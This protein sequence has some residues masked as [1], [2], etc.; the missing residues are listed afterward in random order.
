MNGCRVT[1]PLPARR[2]NGQSIVLVVL[3]MVALL[4]M[5][6]VAI[7]VGY[8]LL[9]KRR[10]QSAVD[11][12]LL[13]GARDLPNATKAKNR[14]VEFVG[15]NFHRVTDQAI[16]TNA[17]TGCMNAGCG[18]HDKISLSA[19][20][21]TPTFF[22]KL[23]G[24]DD[25]TV[26]AR[27]AACGPC[28]SSPFAYDVVVVLDRSYS[29]CLNAWGGS[30]GCSDLA[31][32]KAGVRELLQFFDPDT[33]RVSLA[34]LSSAD[35]NSCTG[36]PSCPSSTTYGR[37]YSHTGA[38]SSYS[39][40]TGSAAG[41]PYCNDSASPSHA[42]SG[43]NGKFY[44]SAGDFMDGNAANHDRW[45]LVS[46]A[47]G[48]NFK[49]ANGT[50]N[51]NSAFLNTLDCIQHK[52]WT[53]IAPAIYEATEELRLNGRTVDDND[54]PVTKVIVFLGDG[55]G[56]AQPM[57]R[58]ND[59]TPT[60]TQSWYTPTA[61][62]NNR[63]CHDAVGQAN[64]ARSFGIQVFT[65]GYAL[66]EGD[67]ATCRNNSHNVESGIDAAETMEEMADDEAHFFEQVSAGDVT[68]IFQQIGHSIVTGG[69]RLVE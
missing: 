12:A 7:D 36:T 4:G 25:W 28:D 37:P 11:L 8:A 27:G 32:A 58:N 64:R 62:N 2:E 17:T 30:N 33:D 34:V 10:L 63:P 61:G 54:N 65:I 22:A 20:T 57:R 41:S 15:T 13:S 18:D 67:A 68:E 44:R 14:A 45:V 3:A 43:S 21:E 52:Y 26:S 40:I 38:G 51:E 24:I 53:P 19:S 16:S 1:R 50:L 47:Q 35:T 48:T 56:T 49:N 31:N 6:G 39:W 69:T 55:G 46:L 5:A 42:Y 60:N 9:Q 29:M 23:F 59:G 66:G